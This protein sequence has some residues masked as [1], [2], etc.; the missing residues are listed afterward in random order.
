MYGCCRGYSGSVGEP[1]GTKCKGVVQGE[2][3]IR[4]NTQRCLD[5]VATVQSEPAVARGLSCSTSLPA[6]F[7]ITAQQ[8]TC[9]YAC[10]LQNKLILEPGERR[11]TNAKKL[12]GMELGPSSVHGDQILMMSGP[13]PKTKDSMVALQ[14]GT[15]VLSLSRDAAE[16]A[17]KCSV[18]S[19]LASA[20]ANPSESSR[21]CCDPMKMGTARRAAFSA[22]LIFSRLS[23]KRRRFCQTWVPL[24]GLK[25][26][27][28]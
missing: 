24:N 5:G 7:V 28:L 12:K 20:I 9:L 18:A 17:L 26:S 27:L 15:R 8:R 22:I 25:Q 11:A 14:A 4:Q 1:T 16:A 2:Q 10:L 13:F 3:N 21:T 19:C 6:R 23:A